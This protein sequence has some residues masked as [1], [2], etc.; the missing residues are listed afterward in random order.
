MRPERP[1]KLHFFQYRVDSHKE[2]KERE[3]AQTNRKILD[4]ELKVL[5]N[6]GVKKKESYTNY[7]MLKSISN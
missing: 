4:E 7:D 2:I 6:L 3:A 5:V 1:E